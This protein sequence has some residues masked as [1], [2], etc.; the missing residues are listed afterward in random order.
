MSVSKDVYDF[1][2]KAGSLEGYV[3][4][5]RM[6]LKYLPQWV[7]NLVSLYHRLPVDVTDEIQ[8]RCDETLGR[9]IQALL[10]VLGEDDEVI[11][12]LRGLLRGKGPSSPDDFPHT[13]R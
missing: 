13:R 1:A 10:L 9:A 2:A 8:D 5:K 6:D 7:E 3:Y 12:K 11:E 4:P